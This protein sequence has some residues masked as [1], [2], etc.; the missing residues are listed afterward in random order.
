MIKQFDAYIAIGD[1]MS[2]DLYPFNDAYAAKKTS[3]QEIGAASLLI[4]NDDEL[5]PDFKGKDLNSLLPGIETKN[6]AFDGATTNGL[7][8]S[9][10]ASELEAYTDKSTLL[11]MS[12]GGN[13]L[14]TYLERTA[15]QKERQPM[16]EVEEVLE[17]IVKIVNAIENTLPKSFLVISNL[18]DPSDGTGHIPNVSGLKDKS[19]LDWLG[20]MNA[21][22]RNLANKNPDRR[23]LAD[24][25]GHFLGHGANAK[26]EDDYWYWRASPIEPGWR[27]AS[28]IRRLWLNCI[29]D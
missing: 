8:D 13:D 25:H 2:I 17:R 16:A 6:A 22:L 23:A 24:L 3:N 18:Y 29:K 11:T 4:K 26:V 9:E 27:G 10:H 19:D 21:F 15:N 20:Y 14:L 5:F 28:E 12:I 7:L 1:S